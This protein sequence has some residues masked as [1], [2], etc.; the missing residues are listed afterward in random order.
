MK[1]GI[2]GY[3]EIGKS[4]H[5]VYKDFEGRFEVKIKEL[6]WSDNF[7]GMSV[8]NVSIP[9]KDEETFIKVVS[10]VILDYK[11]KL[12]IIH[13]TVLPGVTDKIRKIVRDA[14]VH[15]PVR[16]VHPNLYEGLKTFV[17]YVGYQHE[18]EKK[19]AKKHFKD[20]E[21]K[22]EMIFGSSNTELAKLYST[23]YYGLCIAFHGEMKRHFDREDLNFDTINKWNDTYNQGYEKLG[24]PNVIRPNLIPPD[25]D[26]IG[27]H[28]I[29]P[30][31]ELLKGVFDSEALDFI[32]KYK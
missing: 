28:C 19:I 15:S 3:G 26:K 4:L 10:S 2:L 29:I 7:D 14:V 22:T 11:P 5:E 24:K 32:L 12:T 13:S 27:G 30:N 18:E 16:G 8:L 21:V 1:V 6:K 25:N 23:T 20:L 31:T 17:K 9:F